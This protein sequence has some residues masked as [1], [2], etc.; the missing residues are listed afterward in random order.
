MVTFY[1]RQALSVPFRQQ[2]SKRA[3]PLKEAE[4]KSTLELSS[5]VIND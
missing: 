5:R 3:Q 4:P 2:D 1:E